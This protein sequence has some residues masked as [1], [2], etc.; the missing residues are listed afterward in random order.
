MK[1][2]A[3]GAI[4]IVI[5]NLVGKAFEIALANLSP[6]LLQTIVSWEVAQV[7]A[8]HQISPTAMWDRVVLMWS[9]QGLWYMVTH[10]V[11]IIFDLFLPGADPGL[12][13]PSGSSSYQPGMP[14]NLDDYIIQDGGVAPPSSAQIW[15]T[16]VALQC[17]EVLIAFAIVAGS[18]IDKK[19]GALYVVVVPAAIIAVACLLNVA[20]YWIYLVIL[21]VTMPL[22]SL[23]AISTTTSL[24]GTGWWAW[25][26][27]SVGEHAVEAAQD[28]TKEHTT[29]AV[30]KAL[31][32]DK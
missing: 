17:L 30:T 11:K 14:V 9:D 6:D 5:A 32:L 18:E 23:G 16:Q 3:R 24:A 10:P 1:W 22:F 26:A 29:K 25:A 2:L 20:V 28:A 21:T 13:P 27:R 4:G 8:L 15:P 31:R 12:L 19:V 7:T